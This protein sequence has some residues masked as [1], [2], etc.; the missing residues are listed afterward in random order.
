MVELDLTGQ[1]DPGAGVFH[2]I[3]GDAWPTADVEA[4]S[5]PAIDTVLGHGM[6]PGRRTA[7][8]LAKKLS[9][10][11]SA[12]GISPGGSSVETASGRGDEVSISCPSCSMP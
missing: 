9:G 4:K 5:N 11:V 6:S 12:I 2:S 10:K 8:G 1:A 7:N 3:V